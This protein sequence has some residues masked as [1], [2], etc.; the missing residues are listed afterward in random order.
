MRGRSIGVVADKRGLAD[1]DVVRQ[2]FE[3]SL[4]SEYETEEVQTPVD[5]LAADA[6]RRPAASLDGGVFSLTQSIEGA[7]GPSC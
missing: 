7:K 5:V 3:T 1:E 6:E 2:P 4:K